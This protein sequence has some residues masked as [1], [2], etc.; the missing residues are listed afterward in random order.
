MQKRPSIAAMLRGHR[1]LVSPP[2]VSFDVVA[3]RGF[4]GSAS[5]VPLAGSE[6]D[7]AFVRA[8]ASDA[9]ELHAHATTAITAAPTTCRVSRTLGLTRSLKQRACRLD[10]SAATTE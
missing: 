8:I 2:S 10:H 5:L 4:G 3:R 6:A 9:G 1:P 7:S